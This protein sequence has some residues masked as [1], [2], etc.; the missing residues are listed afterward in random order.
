MRRFQNMLASVSQATRG[1]P[2]AQR[3]ARLSVEGMEDRTVPTSSATLTGNTL[4]ITADPGTFVFGTPGHPP[5][6]IFRHIDFLNDPFKHGQ[7]DVVDNGTTIGQF[8]IASIQNVDVTVQGLDAITFDDSRGLP[9]AAGTAI[10]LDGTSPMFRPNTLTFQGNRTVTGGE[11]YVAGNGATA[12]SLTAGGS[13]YAFSGAIASVTDLL[14]TTGPLFVQAFGS[15]VYQTGTDHI[16]QQL[17]GLAGGI[18]G[19]GT[20]TYS[21]KNFVE[22]DLFSNNSGAVLEAT[23][24]ALGEKTFVVGLGDT[25]GSVQIVATPAHVSTKVTAAGT[26]QLVV[27]A[28]NAGQV[29]VNGTPSTVVI[30]GGFGEGTTSGIKNNV[31]VEGAARL[32][33]ADPGNITRKEAVSITESTI[34]GTGLFGNDKAVVH[35]K[36]VGLVQVVT[37]QQADTYSVHGSSKG[38]RF[39]SQIEIDD[40][41][42]VALGVTVTV[43]SGSG[44]NLNLDN[45]NFQSPAAPASLFIKGVGGTFNPDPPSLDAKGD[46]TETV[47]FNGGLTSTIVYEGFTQVTIQK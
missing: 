27:V 46:G 10:T 1:N 14:R 22:V 33:V 12:G 30:L 47:S 31:T 13:T 44:L 23:A 15:A 34:A 42:A 26:G 24:P 8:P 29:S 40:N 20:L 43:D 25:G 38:A 32:A 36:N 17:T 11:T 35:Y 3:R 45:A 19:G 41:S 9:F 5:I 18:G 4:Q 2:P 16:T 6:Q 28:G 37:G 21:H 39:G 7:M